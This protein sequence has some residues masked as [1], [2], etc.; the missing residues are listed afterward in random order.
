MG[1]NGRAQ[2]RSK[3]RKYPRSIGEGAELSLATWINGRPPADLGCPAVVLRL[4][5]LEVTLD[6][7]QQVV[8]GPTACRWKNRIASDSSQIDF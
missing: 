2:S 4:T 1:N 5:E 7:V 6:D 3:E 8:G